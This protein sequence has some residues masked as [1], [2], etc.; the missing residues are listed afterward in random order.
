MNDVLLAGVSHKAAQ[1]KL[2]RAKEMGETKTHQESLDQI[3][4]KIPRNNDNGGV[5]REDRME[6]NGK[7]GVPFGLIQMEVNPGPRKIAAP[8]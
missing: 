8:T 1:W 7:E 5:T 3:C 6:P 4:E 2:Y